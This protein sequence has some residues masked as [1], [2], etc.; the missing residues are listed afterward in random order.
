MK[1]VALILSVLLPLVRLTSAQSVDASHADAKS[2][3]TMDFLLQQIV[4]RA[5]SQEGRNDNLFDMNYQYDRI[6][7][8]EYRNNRGELK[9]TKEKSSVENKSLSIAAKAAGQSAQ[10]KPALITQNESDTDSNP[11]TTALKLKEYSVPDLVKRFQ[12][13]LVGR[14]KLNGRPAFVVDFKPASDQLEVKSLADNFI[15]KTAGRIWVDEQ[16]SAIAQ[17]QLHLTEQVNV[18]GGVVGPVRKFTCAFTRLRT[19]EGYWFVRNMDWHLEGRVVVVNRIVD[20]HERKINEQR[21][22]ATVL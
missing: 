2:L 5:V 6:R 11:S 10:S 22:M 20:Y 4:N 13:T 1:T 7:T 15:N 19:P 17:A 12:F 18:L 14:E 9:S 8:W 16:D 21:I 3:P